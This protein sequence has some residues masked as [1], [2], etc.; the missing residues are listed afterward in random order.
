MTVLVGPL[1]R[2]FT[3]ALMSRSRLDASALFEVLLIVSW[4]GEPLVLAAKLMVQGR[5]GLLHTP[6]V[7][8][9]MTAS[10]KLQSVEAGLRHV[11]LRGAMSSFLLTVKVATAAFAGA[12]QPAART[13]ASTATVMCGTRG[14]SILGMNVVMILSSWPLA[15]VTRRQWRGQ[16]IR[17][18]LLSDLLRSVNC[19]NGHAARSEVPSLVPRRADRD[20]LPAGASGWT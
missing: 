7:L 15:G 19:P 14:L 3:L 6:D 10:R 20:T 2:I 4:I 5:T 16:A 17:P 1:P 8:T 18:R 9:L 12:I 13:S 11:V